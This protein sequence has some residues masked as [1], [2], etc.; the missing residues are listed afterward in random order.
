MTAHS[1]DRDRLRTGAES[2]LACGTFDGE[3][4]SAVP[5]L[6]DQL[7]RAEAERD[8][9][10]RQYDEDIV[11]WIAATDAGEAYDR[12]LA[13][14]DE[15]VGRAAVREVLDD[16]IDAWTGK[17]STKDTREAAEALMFVVRPQFVEKIRKLEQARSDANWALYSDRQGGA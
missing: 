9:A 14:H 8:A 15:R 7:D 10:R 5:Q 12:W 17:D 4:I 6:L 16:I 1:I 11:H 2:S 3:V 13:D